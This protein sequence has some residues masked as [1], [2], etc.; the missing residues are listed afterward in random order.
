MP[1]AFGHVAAAAAT[2][3]AIARAVVAGAVATAD[4]TGADAVVATAMVAFACVATFESSR[5][6][7]VSQ[8]IATTAIAATKAHA[9]TRSVCF[10][11]DP[12]PFST[13][14]N[15]RRRGSIVLG[16]RFG[17][18]DQI[19]F[20][21]QPLREVYRDRLELVRLAD[22][23]G[24][25]CYHKSEHHMVPLDAAP[26]IGLFFAAAA[27]HTTRIRFGTLVYLLPFHH[28]IRLAE[29]I[30]QLDHLL[31][32]RFEV[33]VGKGVSLPEHELWGIDPADAPG[34]FDESLEV[35][36]AA[37]TND[38]LTYTGERYRYDDLPIIVR[39]LQDPHPPFWYAGNLRRAAEL[40]MNCIVGGPLPAVVQQVAA[41]RSLSAPTA[42]IGGV[43]GIY[44][45]PTDAEARQR[46]RSA[47]AVFSERLTPLFRRW[48]IT[49]PNDPTLGGDVDRALELGVLVAGSPSTVRAHVE[50]FREES[51]TDYFVGKFTLG[52]L[53]HAEVMRSVGLFA[54]R[55]M[56]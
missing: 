24:F 46:V 8:M 7:T 16:M 13:G 11:F 31:G 47:W 2:V 35:L 48:G 53:T 49:P 17:I 12:T 38:R 9:S 22:E 21:G 23:A 29:E 44:V 50:R 19:E 26:N 45:A 20:N 33:G 55:C 25:W 36:K 1:S 28:P 52:D 18:F 30:S 43:A 27:Q 40:G 32:G 15:R 37:L 10:V 14:E 34:T 54:E 6:R 5:N 4:V 39:P 42:T 3:V 51:G 41:F 56:V